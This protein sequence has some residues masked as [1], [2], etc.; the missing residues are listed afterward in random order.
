[1]PQ[2]AAG[3]RD[4]GRS[5][6]RGQKSKSKAS[7]WLVLVHDSRMATLPLCLP[8]ESKAELQ[9]LSLS[10]L[11]R[12]QIASW[13]S[14]LMASSTPIPSPR[15]CLPV[16][17]QPFAMSMRGTDIHF[18]VNSADCGVFCACRVLISIPA[19]NSPPPAVTTTRNYPRQVPVSP[20]GAEMP[21]SAARLTRLYLLAPFR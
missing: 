12:A 16:G 18:T 3:T 10:L 4:T 13:E 2:R 7:S 1:M 5:L 11:V 15:C 17:G 14:V 21:W 6:P 19:C 9:C 20:V 8:M